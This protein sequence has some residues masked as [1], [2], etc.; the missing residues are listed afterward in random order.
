MAE[1][2]GTGQFLLALG[3]MLLLGM[4]ADMLGRRTFLPR[5]SLLVVFGI[6]IGQDGLDLIP[7][8]LTDN[9]DLIANMALLMIG[10]L[11]GGKLSVASFRESGKQSLWISCMTVVGTVLFVFLGLLI[12][13]VSPEVALLLGCI[14]SATAPA[15]T[16][17]TVIASGSQGRFARKLLMVVALDDAWGLVLFGFALAA[18]AAVQSVNGVFSPAL[19]ALREMGGA[20]VL[21]LAI[22]IPGAYLTGRLR[23]GEPMLTEALSLVFICGGLA[24]WLDVSFLIAAMVMGSAV[25]NLARHHEYPFHAIEDIEWPFLV[26]F[27][28][29][30]GASLDLQA[31]RGVGLIGVAYVLFRVIGKVSGAYFGGVISGADGPTR[32]WMGTALLPQAGVAIGM[33]LVAAKQIPDYGP[34]LLTLVIGTTIVF[35]I[36]GPAFTRLAIR[37]VDSAQ[38]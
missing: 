31:L 18:V 7:G 28:V 23:P 38:K 14:A 6:I 17:D 4:A 16:V 35:E 12:V 34:W 3:G 11:L 8:P 19:F 33:A 32:R 2:S 22:G 13:G 20:V 27:F 5:V 15:A 36:I 9:F 24:E 26:L 25:F 21:G 30:A 29:L 1:M 37:S 10:F